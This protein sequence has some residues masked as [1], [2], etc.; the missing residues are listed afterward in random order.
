LDRTKLKIADR[1]SVTDTL[2]NLWI[3]GQEEEFAK[4]FVETSAKYAMSGELNE[5]ARGIGIT[6][7]IFNR[8]DNHRAQKFSGIAKDESEILPVMDA[9]A[10]DVAEKI[11]GATR[12][13]KKQKSVD[14]VICEIPQTPHPDKLFRATPPFIEEQTSGEEIPTR[15][16]KSDQGTILWESD[17]FIIRSMAIGDVDGDGVEELAVVSDQKL[18]L[19]TVG[20]ETMKVKSVLELQAGLKVYAIYLADLNAN[21]RQEIIVAASLGDQPS[22]W[23]IEWIDG[24]K[25][26]YLLND[27]RGYLRPVR[28][29]TGDV[30]LM[31]Q[32][33]RLDELLLPDIHELRIDKDFWPVRI[34]TIPCAAGMNIFNFLRV[35]LDNDGG[36]ETAYIDG[37]NRLNLLSEK[38]A[39]LWRSTDLYGISDHYI[40]KNLVDVENGSE[41]VLYHVPSPIMAIDYDNDGRPELLVAK[42]TLSSPFIL[43]NLRQIEEGVVELLSWNGTV[44]STA[45]HSELRKGYMVATLPYGVGKT[46]EG[47]GYVP[48]RILLGE[49]LRKSKLGLPWFG[50]Y[51]S[52]IIEV[53]Q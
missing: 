18:I 41:R 35:D 44:M 17:D 7:F 11:F 12:P 23:V 28:N 15:L 21:G 1:S 24:N 50:G 39:L 14:P 34:K 8:M 32:Y 51:C 5:D 10:W 3:S 33:G 27:Y 53:K 46:G 20:M 45:W 30:T 38:G 29:E 47:V 13:D 37:E 16:L 22:S 31:A 43:K 6:L 26:K 52:R 36:L 9:L 40:G 4:T 42:N 48:P 49:V 2:I 19:L 25:S